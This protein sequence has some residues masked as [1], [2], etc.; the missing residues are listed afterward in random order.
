M[1]ITIFVIENEKNM[2]NKN[3][4]DDILKKV[5]DLKDKEDENAVLAKYH[6]ITAEDK[7]TF[8]SHD[9]L[10]RFIGESK[11]WAYTDFCEVKMSE[12]FGDYG[13]SRSVILWDVR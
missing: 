7:W 11:P 1:E 3:F 2:M 4:P 6:L 13:A 8:H 10:M 12:W 9:E 5:T